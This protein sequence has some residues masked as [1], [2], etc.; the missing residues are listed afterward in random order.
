MNKPQN[1]LILHFK[2][3]LNT[4]L[5]IVRLKNDLFFGIIAISF[6]I[7]FFNKA[8]AQCTETNAAGCVCP[9]PGNTNCLLM[10]DIIAGKKSLN[11]TTGWT[12]YNQIIAGINKGLLRIDVSTPN[13]GSG[14]LETVSTN[15]YICGADT[16]RNFFPTS[17]FLCPDGSAPKRLIKQKI[18][19]KVNNTFQFVLRDAGWMQYHPSHGHIHIEGWGQYTLRLRDVS[20]SDTL[21]WP[22][23]NS[24]IKVSFCLID[25][26]TCSGSLGDCRDANG[27]ILNNASFPNY[28]LA[29]GYSCG[30]TRQGISVG[31][32]DIYSRGL[33]ESFVKIPY[34]ACNGNYFVMIQIDPD[35]HFTEVSENNNWLAAAIPLQQ[36]RTTNTGAYSYIFSKKGNIMCAGSS[37]DLE[38]SGASNYVWSNGATTQKTTISQPGKYWVRATTPCGIATSD[39]LTIVAAPASSIPTVTKGDTVCIGDNANLFA[40]GNPQWFDAPVNGNLIFIGNNFQTG[41]LTANTTFYVADQPSSLSGVLGPTTTNF[42]NAG[43]FTSL[44]SDYLIFNAFLPFKLKKITVNANAAG[45]RRFQLRDMYG[46]LIAEKQVTLVLGSQDVVLDFFVPAAMNL[47][48]GLSS[49]SPLAALYTSNTTA[50]NIG[51][52]FNLKSVGKIVGSSL[53]DTFYPFCYNWQVEVIPQVCNSG[54]RKAVVAEVVQQPN[55]DIV[56]LQ[57]TYLHTQNAV[58]L[59]LTPAGGVLN[60]PGLKGNTFYPKLAG[61]GTH[62]FTYTIKKGNCVNVVS[63]SVTVDFDNAVMQDG[64][65]IQLFNNPGLRQ[66]L[67]LVTNQSSPVEI[68]LLNSIGQVIKKMNVTA[69]TGSNTFN[70]DLSNL[71]KSMYVLDVRMAVSGASKTIKL[72]N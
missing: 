47:Q 72:V 50:A 62:T 5:C 61:V 69:S 67:Y 35:N 60:G 29:G 4:K 27:N 70:L 48:L 54:A 64:F 15:D 25:L 26:T 18:Y 49:A 32:V 65:S 9:I 17:N 20:V 33:D 71:S 3:S 56:G 40:S 28:G 31:K 43:N 52:P 51:Y 10:P 13:V 53:G 12:E 39:T 57:P 14:P 46:K 36:Q 22:I 7:L 30:E 68:R 6:C 66:Q 34:E 55:A 24:G 11:S 42:S 58:P 44:K 37:L 45:I 38:A 21:Q 2:L 59:T 23:V 8:A 19:H 1:F 63:K 16:L 41:T